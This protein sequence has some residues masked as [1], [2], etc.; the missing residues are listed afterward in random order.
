MMQCTR[1]DC[2]CKIDKGRPAMF[3]SLPFSHALCCGGVLSFA[4]HN[5]FALYDR[6]II[7][8]CCANKADCQ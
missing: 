8:T 2:G 1:L 3:L 5:S 4:I 7:H 6:D